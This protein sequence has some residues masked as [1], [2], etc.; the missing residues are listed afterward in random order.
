MK[1]VLRVNETQVTQ[2]RAG[3]RAVVT[4]TGVADPVGATLDKISPVA[5]SSQRWWNP[6]LREYP[7]ELTLDNTPPNL[8]PGI[9]VKGEV[10]VD[11]LS[12]VVAVPLAALYTEKSNS[13]VFIRNGEEV[14]PAAVKAGE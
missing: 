3:Q 6:D 14:N 7:V 12:D 5:D 13:Y 1:G 2:L 8:K 11:R 4:I 9:S 10:Y